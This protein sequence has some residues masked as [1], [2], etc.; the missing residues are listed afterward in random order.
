LTVLSSEPRRWVRL[1]FPAKLTMIPRPVEDVFESDTSRLFLTRRAPD[2]VDVRID[3]AGGHLTRDVM[4]QID[5]IRRMNAPVYIYPRWPGTTQYLW[6]LR[7]NL[8]GDPSNLTYTGTVGTGTTLY[9]I[10]AS[11]SRG[12]H[13]EAV[14]ATSPV[15]LPGVYTAEHCETAFPLGQGVASYAP[16]SNYVKNSLFGA[17]TANVPAN[18]A[19]T[20]GTPGTDMGVLTNSWLGTPA[21]WLWGQS[22]KWTSDSIACTAENYA[23]VSF[24]W[25]SDGVLTVTLNFN[26]GTDIVYSLG[27]GAGYQQAQVLLPLTATSVTIVVQG[28]SGM[29]YAEFSAPQ[30]VGVSAD[31]SETP[32]FL[33]GTG[34]GVNGKLSSCRMR[35]TGLDIEPHLS[36][37]GGSVDLLGL[38]AVSGIIQPFWEDGVSPIYGIAAL[39]NSRSGKSISAAVQ[40]DPTAIGM[41]VKVY[42]DGVEQTTQSFAHTRG[43]AYAFCFYSGQKSLAA[44]IVL[45]CKMARV[46]TPG[47]VWTCGVTTG[48]DRYTCFDQ[49]R[50]GET[51]ADDTGF[52][53]ILGG[54]AVH[55]IRYTSIDGYLGFLASQDYLDLWRQL[56]SRQY[57]LLPSLSPSPWGRQLWGGTGNSGSLSLTQYRDL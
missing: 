15:I 3:F 9:A 35:A 17:V 5:E 1:P 14:D 11:S 51:E 22:A 49:I 48:I 55:T 50:V 7:R 47:T 30:L 33:G 2:A 16:R 13:L 38:I 29:T 8:N 52:D 46:G 28:G 20:V 6:P 10:R 21:L 12:V 36:L 44:P 43:D 18:W 24:G 4:E 25:K 42:Q 45:G 56:Y 53:G 19:A 40:K 31:E 39:L 32:Y 41:F 37:S 34:S 26:A 57:R 54:Y 23:A 27:P